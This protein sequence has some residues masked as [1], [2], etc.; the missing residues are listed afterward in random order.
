SNGVNSE[1][2]GSQNLNHGGPR[3][4]LNLEAEKPDDRL[5]QR[6]VDLGLPY[7]TG[8]GNTVVIKDPAESRQIGIERPRHDADL[9]R[10]A[11]AVLNQAENLLGRRRN[12]VLD[13]DGAD[14]AARA[15]DS[16]GHLVRQ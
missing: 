5:D 3:E 13:A 6:F 10:I 4:G 11:V 15:A 1:G 9:Q 8:E 14:D 7:R 16:W 2:G 12:L